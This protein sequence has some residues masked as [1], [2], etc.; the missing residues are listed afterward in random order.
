MTDSQAIKARGSTDAVSTHNKHDSLM[1]PISQSHADLDQEHKHE[2]PQGI[3]TSSDAPRT[4]DSTQQR[5]PLQPLQLGHDPGQIKAHAEANGSNDTE[6]VKV[7]EID[8][9]DGP[10]LRRLS[11]REKLGLFA[12]LLFPIGTVI[13]LVCLGIL[14]FLWL[15]GSAG[16]GLWHEIT[17][18]DRLSEIVN[19]IAEVI[20]VTVNFQ[21]GTEVAM[22]A[23]LAME[24]FDVLLPHAASL[25]MMKACASSGTVLVLLKYQFRAMTKSTG[26]AGTT[27]SVF[28]MTATL[29]VVFGVTQVFSILLISDTA[30]LAIP[31]IPATASLTVGSSDAR[32]V[33]IRILQNMDN[34]WLRSP[35]RYPTF[36]EYSEPPYAADG[37]LDTGVTLRAFLPFSGAGNR[38]LLQS[39]TGTATVLDA[40]VTCQ[41]PRF[42]NLTVDASKQPGYLR[43]SGW[44]SPTVITPRM[45]PLDIFTDG[46]GGNQTFNGTIYFPGAVVPLQNNDD[47]FAALSISSLDVDL[48]ISEFSELT[49]V[50]TNPYYAG[51]GYLV[52]NVSQ[53]TMHDWSFD[54]P[55][56]DTAAR[57]HPTLT[58][59]SE[60]LDIGFADDSLV[61]S[62]SLCYSPWDQANVPVQISSK[63][64]NRSESAPSYDWATGAYTF[65]FLRKLYGQNGML[66]PYQ[67]GIL[68]MQNQSWT[69]NQDTA[70]VQSDNTSAP[71]TASTSASLRALSKLLGSAMLGGIYNFVDLTQSHQFL[72][73]F[74]SMVFPLD[75]YVSL[76]HEIIKTTQ[77]G[78]GGSGIAFML[79]SLITLMSSMTYYDILNAYDLQE[80]VQV[81]YFV[82]A[83]M[84]DVGAGLWTV[85]AVLGVHLALMAVVLWLFLRRTTHS[86]LGATWAAVAAHMQGLGSASE[87]EGELG[88]G[89]GAV[90]GRCLE[91]AARGEDD[92]CVE[93]RMRSEGVANRRVGTRVVGCKIEVALKED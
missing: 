35:A 10:T 56:N 4:N 9:V 47:D 1:H 32:A 33:A 75:T 66:K 14:W 53:G 63:H 54:F 73:P 26:G 67:R 89:V 76:A 71:T 13:L 84:P 91:D 24:R 55:Y 40:R 65:D 93:R 22:I 21:V 90:V 30:V 69:Q 45:V 17:A 37:V 15:G 70:T 38:Q 52:L 68:E 46:R 80:P 92:D 42:S 16:S 51:V 11:W 59:R 74:D 77:G 57:L 12:L 88:G 39:Y 3:S 60:W 31:G 34:T 87:G 82:P 61:V 23:S 78:G 86:R 81:T 2:Q 29:S 28:V 79:Q 48:L 7:K 49:G 44:V 19:I 50:N 72:A 83:T 43:L 64:N 85:T 8:V 58:N 25:S 6:Q 41:R 27:V 20:K 18:R 5:L 36:A 62:A